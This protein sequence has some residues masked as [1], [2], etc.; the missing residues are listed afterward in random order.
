MLKF[1][2]VDDHSIVRRGLKTLIE[3][4]LPHSEIDESSGGDGA[5]ERIRKN[6][7][8][9]VILDVNMPETDSLGL[10]SNILSVRSSQKI[11]MFSINAEEIYAKRYLKIGARG[12]LR[13]DAQSEEIQNAIMTVLNNKRYISPGLKENFLRSLHENEE[14]ENPFNK[15][16]AREFEIV[17]HLCRGD[18]VST[19]SQVFKLHTSTIGTHKARIFQKLKCLNVVELSDLAKL[20][21][22]I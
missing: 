2:L 20:H 15:L 19:I 17:Q 12:Y 21:R 18:S 8:D 22:L 6:D 16:S 4:F 11:M 13:K 9:L 5:L 7:Y 1:L 3:S 10:V 14:P